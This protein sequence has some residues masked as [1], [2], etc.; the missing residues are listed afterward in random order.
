MA[1]DTPNPADL[2]G[3]CDSVAIVLDAAQIEIW[4][5]RF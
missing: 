2:L 5:W 4:I 3:L 1:A